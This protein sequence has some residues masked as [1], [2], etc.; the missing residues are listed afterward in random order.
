MP[1][2]FSCAVL[3][4]ATLATG[5]QAGLFYGYAISVMPGLARADA[6]TEVT[7]MRRIN[8]AIQNPWF[9]AT[10]LGAPL[11]I[12]AAAGL[13]LQPAGR[14][15]LPWIVAAL[16]LYA[17]MFTVTAT[18]NVPLNERLDATGAAGAPDDAG[19]IRERFHDR[20]VRWNNVRAI[21]CASA[22]GCLVVAL[23]VTGPTP[24]P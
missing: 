17:T 22:F 20:W 14:A 6:R 2:A 3:A 23:C 10:F 1:G 18:V 9:F 11:F 13:H 7:A 5:H 24:A 16:V 8:T 19:E 12:L 15:A 21:A 4:L